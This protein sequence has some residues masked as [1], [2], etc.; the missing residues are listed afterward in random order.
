[1]FMNDNKAAMDI[2][3]IYLFIII[4]FLILFLLLLLLLFI[5]YAKAAECGL[6]NAK[7]NMKQKYY[8]YFIIKSYT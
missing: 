4:I 2:K 8:F 1:M 5:Y 7:R 6:H 3:L